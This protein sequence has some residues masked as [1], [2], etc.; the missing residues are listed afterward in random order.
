MS[1]QFPDR[2]I[3]FLEYRLSIV[4]IND[5]VKE[6]VQRQI[7]AAIE[8]IPYDKSRMS[9]PIAKSRFQYRDIRFPTWL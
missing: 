7:D 6:E 8:S 2:N 9:T 1:L 4:S 5:L 3:L